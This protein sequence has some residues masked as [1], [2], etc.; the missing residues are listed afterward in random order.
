[1]NPD[2]TPRGLGALE[3]SEADIAEFRKALSQDIGRPVTESDDE[4]RM[5]ALDT[6]NAMWVLRKIAS[7]QKK[8]KQ[9]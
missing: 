7:D 3:F 1:M 2:Y 9:V 5:M 6:L 8:R 4:I